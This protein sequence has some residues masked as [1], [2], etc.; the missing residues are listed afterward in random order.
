MTTAGPPAGPAGAAGPGADPRAR[1]IGARTRLACLLGH[2]VAH[3]LSPALHNAAFADARIDAVYLAFDVEPAHLAAAVQ[4]LRAARF[5]GA[6]VTVPHKRAVMALADDRTSEAEAVGAA[7]TLYWEGERLVADNTDATGLEQVLR[8]DL[9]LRGADGVLLFGTG[10]AARAAAV[11]L[12]RIGA[13]VEVRG[14]RP[15]AVEEIA[16]LAARHGAA[17][18]VDAGRHGAGEDRHGAEAARV[19]I[20]ATTLGLAGEALPEAL[21]A[22]RPDQV[23][24]DLVYGRETPFL[25]AARAAGARAEDGLGMLLAQAARSFARWTGHE[26]SQSVMHRAILS[27][28]GRF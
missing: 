22:L 23:A 11:A 2:P 14:R 25:A 24:L 1:P 26:G 8:E 3:S 20:N 7:N 18:P 19:V 17:A 4:G 5:L 28:L 12:G 9:G 16:A 13:A 15:E 6:N 27:T 10:G 21:M